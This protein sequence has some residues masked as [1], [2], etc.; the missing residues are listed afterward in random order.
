MV[1]YVVRRDGVALGATRATTFVDT[2][3]TPITGP[4]TT[5]SP[6]S[7]WPATNHRPLPCSRSPRSGPSSAIT[8]VPF[9]SAWRYL[10]TGPAPAATWRTAGY[11]DT[12][13]AH[14]PCRARHAATATRPPSW[15]TGPSPTC[16]D[17]SPS[18]PTSWW[19]QRRCATCATTAWSSRSTAPRSS[20]TTSP[21]G[22]V[23]HTTPASA[24]VFGDQETEIVTVEL[25]P[26][27]FV[28]G[29]NV[30]A[31]S[32][33]NTPGSGDLSFDAQ[34]D[35]RVGSAGLDTTQPSAP[36][37]LTV[38]SVSE[39]SVGLT[40]QAATDNVAVV[41][42]EIRRNGVAVGDDRPARR[43]STVGL[44]PETTSTYRV[45]ALDAAGNVGP[46][47]G[48]GR[49]DDHCDPR[50]RCGPRR[51]RHRVAHRRPRRRP[52]GRLDDRAD[53]SRHLGDGH[54][55]DRRRRRRR[56]D[57]DHQPTGCVRSDGVLGG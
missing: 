35:L 45:V 47:A 32:L 28:A 30:V 40:W 49:G 54:D 13:L 53:S 3:V 29:T 15:P 11:D 51:R 4:T 25:D 41:G 23:T 6:P 46:P 31:V 18:A 1:E 7:I 17:R 16:V 24:F 43:S 38:A 37:A 36:S 20:A 22:P 33:H 21:P 56:D 2:T 14:R 57:R 52:T 5:P 50:G 27:L 19:R 12:R 9:G 42:Y 10:D 55:R 48:P 34:L 26:T 39:G 44:A 8:P